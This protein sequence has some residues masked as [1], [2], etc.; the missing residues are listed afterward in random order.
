MQT[1]DQHHNEENINAIFSEI[2]DIKMTTVKN[3]QADQLER[4][5]A[6]GELYEAINGLLKILEELRDNGE[7]NIESGE[8]R[9]TDKE[10]FHIYTSLVGTHLE[11]NDYCTM[12]GRRND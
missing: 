11:E 4:P 12:T 6:I 9:I 5:E 7:G 2:D 8:E 10:K 1:A 3:S